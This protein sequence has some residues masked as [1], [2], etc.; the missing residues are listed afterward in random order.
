MRK[1]AASIA[2][3]CVA[4]VGPLASPAEATPP[5]DVEIVVP[6]FEGPFVAT[7]SAVDDGVVCATGEVLTT[8][9]K[10]AGFQSNR[11]VNLQVGKEF[12]CDDGSGTFAAQL[13]VRIDFARGTSFQWV[14][15][16]GTDAYEALHG[17][18]SGF[19]VPADTDIYQGRLH[20]E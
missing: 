7:G 13:Q 10:A 9:V 12:T 2:V 1:I 3:F 5:S 6:G 16:G 14:I 17:T 18:G 19:V 8:D 20:T 4:L 15:T 11:G